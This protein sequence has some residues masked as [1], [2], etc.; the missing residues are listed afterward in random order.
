MTSLTAEDMALIFWDVSSEQRLQIVINLKEKRY[1]LS[2]MAKKLDATSPEVHRNFARLLKS[3]IIEKGVDGYYG[4]TLFGEIIYNQMSPITF[5]AKNKKYFNDHDFGELPQKFIDRIG[6][7]ENS[8]LIKPHV[9]VLECWKNIYKNAEKYVC[10]IL[11]E[12]SYSSDLIEILADKLNGDVKISSIFSD[13]AVVSEERDKIMR[14]KTFQKFISSDTLRRKMKKNIQI[15]VVLNEKEA[16]V[17]FPTKNSEADL[18]KMFY[19]A[20]PS[21]HDWCLDY[22]NYSWS[23]SGSF[24]EHKLHI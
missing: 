1:T 23:N 7:L 9:K 5:V 21:F 16:G 8:K 3:G 22:F 12:I 17:I 2:Q 4:L 10:N 15:V 20:D 6:E 18:S 24:Q 13:V 11:V 19:S 14:E